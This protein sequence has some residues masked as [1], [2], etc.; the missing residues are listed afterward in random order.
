[1]PDILYTKSAIIYSAFCIF[2]VYIQ[3]F[4]IQF[5]RHYISGQYH[6]QVQNP[7]LYNKL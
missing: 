6:N 7:G 5:P 1:M 2:E 3:H 4:T